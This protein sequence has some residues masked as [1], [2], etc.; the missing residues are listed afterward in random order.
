MRHSAPEKSPVKPFLSIILPMKDHRGMAE[1]AIKSWTKE[2]ECNPQ[3]YELILVMDDTLQEFKETFGEML[4]PHDTLLHVLSKNLREQYDLGARQAKGEWLL[5]TEAHCEGDSRCVSEI[6]KHATSHSE[7]GFCLRNASIHYTRFGRVDSRI[8]KEWQK[9]LIERDH[10]GKVIIRGF[11]ISREVYFEVGGLEYKYGPFAD[12]ILGATLHT[13][14]YR[15]GYG[16]YAEVSHF[17][18]HDFQVLDSYLEEFVAGECLY[19]LHHD[20]AFCDRYFGSSMEWNEIRTL[21][22]PLAKMLVENLWRQLIT[23]QGMAVTFWGRKACL[24]RFFYFFLMCLTGKRAALLPWNLRVWWTKMRFYLWYF[25]EK[26]MHRALVA[27][28][29]HKPSLCRI[30]FALRQPEYANGTVS[31]KRTCKTVE[32]EANTL[33]GFHGLERDEGIPFRWSSAIAAIRIRLEP[34]NYMVTLQLSR[35]RLMRPER[36]LSFFLDNFHLQPVTFHRESFC[37]SLTVPRLA[38][39]NSLEHW[40]IIMC[41]PWRQGKV[42]KIDERQLGIPLVAVT[43]RPQKRN[44]L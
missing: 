8:F 14:G 29:R 38:F 3:D 5:F 40:L 21:T 13:K 33:Y 27:F 39:C 1:S 42:H 19:R 7:H 37:L 17:E 34:A 41:N 20:A 26:R 12:S 35:R 28:Y 44:L 31:T 24:E 2:Q 30:Q 32:M 15:L 10:W 4:R 25:N 11:A 16:Q 6:I 18:H 43:F 36:E 22:R 9:E 23:R